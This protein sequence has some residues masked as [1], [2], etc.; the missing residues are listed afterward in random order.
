MIWFRRKPRSNAASI[1]HQA[2]DS[3][4]VRILITLALIGLLGTL[5]EPGKIFHTL[6][7]FDGFTGLLML[8]VNIIL[9]LVFAKRWQVIASGLNFELP[10][11]RLVRA[12]WLASCLSQFGPTLLI[13]EATRFRMLRKHAPANLLIV[14][15]MLDRISGQIVLFLIVLFLFP[16]VAGHLQP[17]FLTLLSS[18]AGVI[19]VAALIFHFL[20]RRMRS[21]LQPGTRQA[22]ELMGWRG[23]TGHYCLSLLVQL[24]LVLN[25]SLAAFGIGI[26]DQLLPFLITLPLVF[27]VLT[28]L[29]ITISDWGSRETAAVILLSPSGLDAETIVS[30]SMLFG[31]FHLLTAL[32]GG[33]L[34]VRGAARKSPDESG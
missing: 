7:E 27:A 9:M 34:L 30:V 14:S 19:I 11:G 29:P 20:Y 6:N 8:S 28:L 21:V 18:L 16:L 17:S 5:L 31:L 25:F 10:Y 23:L 4:L 12:I 15:Q 3:T 13:A 1:F 24:L 32:P 33:L 26:L 2:L 22:I